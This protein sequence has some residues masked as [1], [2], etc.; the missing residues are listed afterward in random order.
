MAQQLHDQ[1]E[2]LARVGDVV[3]HEDPLAG[4]LGGVHER[5][6]DDGLVEGL[7]DAGVE[8]DVHGPHRFD[9][10]RVADGA[11]GYEAAAGDA[12]DEVRHP[13]RGHDLG[14]QFALGDAEQL[15]GELLAVGLGLRG[16]AVVEDGPGGRDGVGGGGGGQ[17]A[18]RLAHS[19]QGSGAVAPDTVGRTLPPPQRS[20]RGCSFGNDGVGQ[21]GRA[22][23][24]GGAPRGWGPAA[25]AGRGSRSAAGAPRGSGPALAP[26][27]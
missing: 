25:S 17:R 3:D 26:W 9:A 10:D 19:A 13:S 21:R 15:P 22:T 23:A 7:A 14:G 18:V 24:P 8:L 4:Q 27:S 1:L 20:R 6:Q 11:G 16:G 12:D 5:G 2:G